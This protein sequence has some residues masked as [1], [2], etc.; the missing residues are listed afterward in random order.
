MK[1]ND[2]QH[3]VKESPKGVIALFLPFLKEGG[4]ER[5]MLNLAEGFVRRGIKVDL[6]LATKAE[7]PY[8]SQ[9]PSQVQVVELGASNPIMSL[10][11]LVR[12]L[13]FRRPQI[14]LSGLTPANLVALWAK[15]ILS[16]KE[17]KVLIQV[18][19][20][21]GVKE[22]TTP[23]R[24]LLRPFVYR[25]FY[26]WA[27]GIVAASEGVAKD[28][29]DFGLPVSKIF[30]IYNPVVTENLYKKAEE[31]INHPWFQ[32]GE[33][34]VVLGVGRLHKQK[35]F[36]TLIRAFALVR[37]QR[38][39]RLMILGEGEE[40]PKLEKLIRE[41]GLEE[42]VSLPGFVENPYAYMKKAS[43]FV[44]SSIYEGFGNVV[45]EALAVG[46]PVVS[47]DCPHGPAEILEG[48]KWGI[49]VPVGNVEALA[50]AIVEALDKSW[51]RDALR[52]RAQSF[53]LDTIVSQYLEVMGI[54]T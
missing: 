35:D 7:G 51:D 11:G 13:R 23:L 25:L 36:P 2:E 44:L 10:S 16:S 26:P 6:V 46:T 40:R 53:S 17:T 15:R 18:Q 52:R 21:V 32:Q 49:L 50:Q 48:G 19:V 27:D 45:A 43:V 8:K 47:T 30:V 4:V 1:N 24:A 22:T 33:Q 20:S 39:A 54:D 38:R 29:L 5:T 12:Y 41:L 31:P 28:L 42:E 14:V 3:M 9:I 37:K 34:P